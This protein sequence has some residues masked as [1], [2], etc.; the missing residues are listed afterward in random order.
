MTYKLYYLFIAVLLITACSDDDSESV[1]YITV[2]SH[3]DS[4][5]P[6]VLNSVA[7][8]SS[9]TDL[10]IDVKDL[11]I[12]VAE[13]DWEWEGFI[14]TPLKRGKTTVT[15]SEKGKLKWNITAIVEYEG[16]GI[17]TIEDSKIIVQCDSDIKDIIE[18]DLLEKSL[19]YDFESKSF[20]TDFYCQSDYPQ[21]AGAGKCRD[22]YYD[23]MKETKEYVF[24]MRSTG[25]E[26]RYKFSL[27]YK[28]GLGVVPQHKIG[29]YSKDRT[30]EYKEKYPDKNIVKVSEEYKVECK[31]DKLP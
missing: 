31:I 7:D 2:Y 4:S 10:V 21:L 30:V 24:T 23:F 26:Y 14:I 19:F 22:L 1:E 8:L 16:E 27:Q 25:E 6:L 12:V 5:E 20:Y 3:L 9:Y 29:I 28:S 11:D 18:Q 13:Y 17:W 15:V